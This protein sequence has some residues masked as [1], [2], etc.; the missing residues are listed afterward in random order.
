[1]DYSLSDTDTDTEFSLQIGIG[2]GHGIGKG[3]LSDLSGTLWCKQLLHELFQFL[4]C[5]RIF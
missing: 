2:I 4:L 5:L 1:M 3:I